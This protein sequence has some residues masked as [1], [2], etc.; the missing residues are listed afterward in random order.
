MP[1]PASR[2]EGQLVPLWSQFLGT[3]AP[4]PTLAQKPLHPDQPLIGSNPCL[5]SPLSLT[6]LSR[7]SPGES[8]AHSHSQMRH[9]SLAG[10]SGLTKD[11]LVQRWL[12][13]DRN[14]RSVPFSL[15]YY[16]PAPF[17]PG[18]S[19]LPSGC[20]SSLL[21]QLLALLSP[22]FQ[23]FLEVFPWPSI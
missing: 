5:C 1:L 6:I 22:P 19:F 18:V 7:V 12:R 16:H 3:S 2:A 8:S 4:A 15:C 11:H 10:R 21:L 13:K 17:P 23:E 20:S 14:G 9:L